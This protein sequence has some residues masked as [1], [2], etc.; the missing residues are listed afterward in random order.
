[1]APK[2]QQLIIRMNLPLLGNFNIFSFFFKYHV[3]ASIILIFIFFARGGGVGGRQNSETNAISSFCVKTALTTEQG[4]RERETETE[5]EREH[6]VNPQTN[7]SSSS[8]VFYAIANQ[9]RLFTS[10]F[11]HKDSKR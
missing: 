7:F 2:K 3:S 8:F 1:M 5:T 4:G 11:L 6:K 10:H 9:K